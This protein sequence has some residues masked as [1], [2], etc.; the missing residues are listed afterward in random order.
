MEVLKKKKKTTTWK[1]YNRKLPLGNALF[2]LLRPS[3]PISNGKTMCYMVRNRDDH[4]KHGEKSTTR[5]NTQKE[6]RNENAE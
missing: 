4:Q 6:V 5:K 1:Q 2:G 3:I